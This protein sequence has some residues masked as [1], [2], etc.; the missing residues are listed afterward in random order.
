VVELIGVTMLYYITCWEWLGRRKEG[1]IGSGTID[2]G[3]TIL[4]GTCWGGAGRS[5]RKRREDRGGRR[6][7]ARSPRGESDAQICE[8]GLTGGERG[9]MKGVQGRERGRRGTYA[10]N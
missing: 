10:C 2:W 7:R 5:R 1:R 3:V 4:Y 6:G 9:R 8:E